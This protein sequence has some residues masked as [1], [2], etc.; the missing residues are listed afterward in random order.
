M[1]QQSVYLREYLVMKKDRH[2]SAERLYEAAALLKTPLLRQADIARALNESDQAVNNW[3]TR[4]TGISAQGC[5]SIQKKLGINAAWLYDGE[6]D[7]FVTCAAA[8]PERPTE[9]AHESPLTSSARSLI[10]AIAEADKREWAGKPWACCTIW[11]GCSRSRGS[12]RTA[13]LTAMIPLVKGSETQVTHQKILAASDSAGGY[14]AAE[15]S[16]ALNFG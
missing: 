7:M 15:D 12:C 4:A 6:G 11:S 1:Y 10:E 16:A 2:P 3:E 5:I 9:R 8:A 13:Q 14:V